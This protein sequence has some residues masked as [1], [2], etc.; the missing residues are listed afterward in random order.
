M[1]VICLFCLVK[2]SFICLLVVYSKSSDAFGAVSFGQLCFGATEGFE[3][4]MQTVVILYY[5]GGRLLILAGMLTGI[6]VHGWGKLAN[7]CRD[8]YW[9]SGTWMGGWVYSTNFEDWKG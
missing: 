1:G 9:L 3:I 5:M 8:A 6:Q 4:V 7:S 2:L